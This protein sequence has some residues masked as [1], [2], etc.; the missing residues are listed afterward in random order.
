ML[1]VVD[2]NI[3]FAAAI[4]DSKTAELIFSDELELIAP[5]YVFFEFNKYMNEILKKTERGSGDFDRFMWILWDRISIVPRE[6]F[7]SLV[8][9]AEEISPDPDDVQYFALALKYDCSVW[10]NDE[11]L[12]E[13]SEIKILSTED[14]VKLLGS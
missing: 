10:S 13:Q 1:L 14:L 12:K 3:L 6:E 8:D 9:K 11:R 7:E 5:E 4:K 2:A